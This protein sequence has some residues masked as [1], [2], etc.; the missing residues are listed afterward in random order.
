MDNPRRAFGLS[1]SKI[2]AFE[3]CP[4][5]LWLQTHKAEVATVDESAEARFATGNS[6]GD[7]AC[8][9]CPN[10]VMIEAKPNFQ[11]ALERT[12]ELLE[13]GHRDAIFE[14]T[15]QHDGVLIRADIMEHD[16]TDGWHVAEVKS[17]TGVKDYHL[18]DMATQLWVMR[19]AGVNVSSA[20]IRHI[21]R[22]FVLEKVGNY[23]GLLSDTLIEAD[24]SE[25]ESNRQA[26]VREAREA[27]GGSVPEIK[28]GSQCTQPFDCEFQSYC[29]AQSGV[30]YPEWPISLLPRTGKRIAEAFAAE[31]VFELTDVP[32]GQLTHKN[33]EKIRQATVSNEPFHDVGSITAE[34]DEWQFPFIHLDFETCNIAIPRWVG[35]KPYQQVPFQFSAHIQSEDGQVTHHEFLDL[36]GNDPRQACAEA[37]AKL[38]EKGAVVAWN[39]SFERR[40]LKELAEAVPHQAER[41][42]S[43]ADRLVDL[44]VVAEKHY[45][46]RDQRGSW[47]IK[48]VLPTLA[49]ELDYGALEVKSGG[50]AVSAYDEAISSGT[51]E[52]R[53]E[54]IGEALK[55]YCER[56][57]WAMVVLLSKLRNKE[58]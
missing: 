9:Q 31:G 37:L 51:S 36:S 17:S 33:H 54:A 44:K 27:L 16:G 20:A 6:V 22:S 41:L 7:L 19:S 2:S 3:Q 26:I 57:T 35:T 53:R 14:A 47:S 32:E 40:C 5:R 4:K 49:N 58:T 48:S 21:D 39:A 10:G 18:G 12:Q 25:L 46:H 38:P 29:H 30:E 55:S 28:T 24:V 42:L 13:A 23:E 34:T 52:G 43:L 11:A 50:E 56:D 8:K 1:K 15:F 45:Y